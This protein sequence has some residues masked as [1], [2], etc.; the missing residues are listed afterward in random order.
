MQIMTDAMNLT[1]K[2][3]KIIQDALHRRCWQEKLS[4]TTPWIEGLSVATGLCLSAGA[5]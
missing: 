3:D 4:E 1:I 2:Q 5:T